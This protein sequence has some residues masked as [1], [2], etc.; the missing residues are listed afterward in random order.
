MAINIPILTSFVDKGITDA[1]G[2]F[3]G[4][5]KSTLIAGAAIA[6]AVTAVAAFAY[7]SIQKA[8]DFN[9]AVSKNAVVFGAISKEVENFAQ[10]A[11][12]ALGIGETAALQ[13]AGTFAIFGKSAGLAGQDLSDFSIEFVTLAADL[14][15][16]SNTKVED[17]ISAIGS[18]LRGEAEPLRKYGV[19]LDDATLKLAATELGIYSGNKALTAQQKVLAAQKVIF[20]QTSDAQGDFSRTSTGL[21]AQQ[22]ILNATLD[23][24][25]TNLGA[26][27]LPIFLKAVKFFNDEVTPAF[28]RVAEVIGEKGLVKGL[29]QA[30][31]EM[32]SFGPGMVEAFKQVAIAAAK[33]AN[34]MYKFAQATAA[35]V[36]FAIGRPMDALKSL[37]KVFDNLID[38]DK[39]GA[40]FTAFA[41]GIKNMGSASDYSSFAAKKLAEDAK[42]A[43]DAVNELAGGGGGGKDKGAAGAAKKL[44][45]LQK[46]AQDAADT[47]REAT[48]AA[49]KDAAE[50]L[51]KEMAEALDTA[52]NNLE[53][54]ETAYNDFSASV[55]KGILSSLS[56]SKVLSDA[57]EQQ[58]K[59]TDSVK[60]AAKAIA[61][62]LK[63]SLE[64]AQTE[65]TKTKATFNDFAKT[66][67]SGIKESFSFKKANEG[68]DGFITGLRDQ[69]TAIKQYNDDI[70]ALLNR[71]LSQDALK[72]ILAAGTESGAAIARGLLTGA[73]DDITGSEGVNALVASVQETSDQ[74]GLASAEMFYGEGVSAAQDYL[75]GIQTQF[76]HAMEKVKALETG[77]AVTTSFVEGLQSQISGISD[78]AADINTLLGMGL[79]QDAL[80]AVLDAGGESGAAIAHEL[81]LGAQ[82]NITGPKGVNA[83]VADIKKVATA[84]GTKAADQWYGT[85]VANAK[86]YLKGV[87]DA[88][89]VAQARLDAAGSG[90]TVADIK[91]IGAGF[92]DQVTNGYTATPLEQFMQDGGGLSADAGGNIVYNINVSGVMS[93]AQTGQA[94][95]DA[96]TQYTQVYGPLNLA[97]R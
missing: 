8:S 23:N 75:D 34:V 93:N 68:E 56:F 54:A 58:K 94:V 32:G 19:L 78:Y 25:Q 38:V 77:E 24:I 5:T 41:A 4:L 7:T 3:G 76:D 35:S 20:E 48:A 2:A 59:L 79:S 97:I 73:Q 71:G 83:L 95:I 72:Q 90:L 37:S 11:N 89:A 57:D 49:V 9:E 14:A 1:E 50:A 30:L 51:N 10:T 16:F 84:I 12:R 18:A 28:E 53:K 39:I 52:K 85:G 91:G 45:A 22:K 61:S 17:A 46:A 70:Q 81:V 74:L 43:A 96:L 87:E 36:Q 6:G 33:A 27:F 69:V 82:D 15:S 42:G 88:F 55:S 21:A 67:S 13:A 64:Q 26:A 29:Q 40:S 65:L 86:E 62:G 44:K 63:V 60:E 47:L 92:F 31:F 80:Q 66:V